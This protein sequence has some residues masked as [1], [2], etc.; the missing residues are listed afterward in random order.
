[1][2]VIGIIWLRD[3]I[4][5]LSWKHNVT[6][7]EV[8]EIF[9]LSPRYRLIETGDIEGENLYVALGQTKEGRYLAVYFVH[10]RT[11]EALIVSARDMTRKER[12][13]YGR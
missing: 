4:D 12:R 8:E 9:D 6:T 3:V 1:M 13:A 2:K 11:G 10:K 7:D 5:K